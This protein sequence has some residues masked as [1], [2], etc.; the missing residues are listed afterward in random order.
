M[1]PLVSVLLISYNEEQYIAKALESIIRQKTTFKFEVICHDDA[2][3]DGTQKI[4]QE[5]YRKYPDIIVPILQANNKMQ[6]G[7]QIVMEYC[8]P[9]V[10]GKY[11]AYCDGD[12]YWIDDEKLQMQVDFLENNPEYS[13]CLHDFSFL[14]EKENKMMRSS[15]GKTERDI[16]VNELITW[17]YKKIPQLGAAVF[18]TDLAKNRPDLFVKIG[19]GKN[20]LRPISDHP[21]YIYLGLNGK[22]KYIPIVMAVWRRR[23]SGTW[24]NGAKADNMVNFNYEKIEFFERLNEYSEEFYKDSINQAIGKCKFD[25]AWIKRNYSEAK[26]LLK[27]SNVS[28]ARRVMV[29]AFAWCPYLA[30]A[31]RRGKCHEK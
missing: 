15:C 1:E 14:Y 23:V 6:K 19:G 27:Y 29:T 21:L 8:Y 20:S 25:N 5:Y 28:F 24:G 4:I 26:R 31:I 13:M 22:V 18:R 9:A 3:T 16:S 12:D 7:H 11:I 17:N 10:K 2:S 30:K